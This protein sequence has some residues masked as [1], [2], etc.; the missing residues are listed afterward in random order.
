MSFER[1]S[2]LLLHITSLPSAGGIGDLGPASY[3]FADF[4]AAAKQRLWQVLPLSPTG[5]GN[6]PYAA[7]SAFAGNPLLVSL[8]K[9]SEWGWID[10]KR[11][12]GLPGRSGNIHF[13]EVEK[14]KMPLLEEAARNFLHRHSE[15][16]LTAQ[17]ARFNAYCRMNASWLNDYAHYSMLR[18]KF[19]FAC[20]NE[21]PKE[22]AYRDPDALS[23]LEKEHGEDLAIE[24]VIQFAF[25]EQWSALRQYCAARDIHFIGDVAIFVNYDSADV[26]THRDIFDLNEDLSPVRVSGVPPDYFSATGQRWGNPLYRWDVLE[27][28]G[29]DWWVDRIRRAH[30]LYD[31]IRLDHFR[32]FEAYWSI[33][34]E[35]DTA[36]NGEWVKAPGAELFAKLRE[37]LGELPVIAEDLGL[38]TPEVEAL[39]ERFDLPGMRVLQ[40]GFSDRGAH[41]YLP[42]RYEKNTVVYTGTHDN[43][44]TRGWWENGAT[45]IEKAAVRTYVNPG[46]DGVV[47]PLI[48]AASTSVADICLFPLQDILELG[49]D[50]RMNVPSRSGDN[51]GWRCPE[52]VL[53]PELAEKLGELTVVTD[54]DRGPDDVKE[55]RG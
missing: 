53:V 18:E 35:D 51:W 31:L 21:W 52:G 37:A 17:W 28:R 24:Q 2:G 46:K 32:G 54:R 10:V 12:A 29:F 8:E 1:S 49:S 23:R 42:H 16:N 3:E 45:E 43:D 22:Y 33:P 9:L 7:L 36:V 13:D 19:N 26:W 5:Y 27:K 50:A 39:R 38:I 4:L 20:W 6:S 47:W 30:S 11:I 15:A 48:R 44:T 41:N 14:K 40:F 34:A 25:D 55:T